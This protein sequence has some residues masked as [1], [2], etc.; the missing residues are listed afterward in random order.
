M[1]MSMSMCTVRR[2]VMALATA[3]TWPARAAKGKKP[4]G[5]KKK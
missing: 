2:C 4:A 5:K 3:A 1:S